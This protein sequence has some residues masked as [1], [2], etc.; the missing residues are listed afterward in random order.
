MK[1]ARSI[2]ALLLANLA[3][4]GVMLA[5][6][7]ASCHPAHAASPTLDKYATAFQQWQTSDK[8]LILW[9]GAE[10]CGPCKTA[11][12]Q[13]EAAIASGAIVVKLDIDRDKALIAL[14]ALPTVS[15]IPALVCYPPRA[16]YYHHYHPGWLDPRRPTWPRLFVGLPG[17]RLFLGR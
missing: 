2:L 6:A 12:Q 1:F 14:H 11:H 17:F 4:I 9:Y 16:P 5:L 8:P 3:I 7:V 15:K 13:Y 10:W